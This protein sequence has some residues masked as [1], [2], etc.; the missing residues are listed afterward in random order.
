MVFDASYTR[1]PID[2][3]QTYTC[4]FAR[5]ARIRFCVSLAARRGIFKHRSVDARNMLAAI[6][7]LH[8]CP[9]QSM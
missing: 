7:L 6:R 9:L 4:L 3:A 1:L 8:F 2:I 5:N